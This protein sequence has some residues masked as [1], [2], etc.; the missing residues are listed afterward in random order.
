MHKEGGVLK[1]FKQFMS[2][3]EY[4]NDETSVHK[5]GKIM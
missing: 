3:I 2:S 4:T 5:L 1:T